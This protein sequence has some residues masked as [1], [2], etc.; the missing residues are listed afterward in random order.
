[1]LVTV[2]VIFVCRL[3]PRTE[4][5]VKIRHSFVIMPPQPEGISLSLS[6]TVFLSTSA[7]TR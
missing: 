7:R 6:L 3:Y 1:M 4:Y 2:V 5:L